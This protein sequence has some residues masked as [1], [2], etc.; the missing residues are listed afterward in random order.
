LPDTNVDEVIK[1]SDFVINCAD[2]PYIGYTS[3]KLSKK[4]YEMNK[5]H[6]IAGGFDI[7]VMS[8]GELIIPGVTPCVNCYMRY[9][10]KKLSNWTPENK[11]VIDY[12]NE[13]GGLASQSLFSASYCVTQ[14]FKYL[15]G[16][17]F[18]SEKLTRGEVDFETYKIQYLDVKRDPNCPV[19]GGL[20]SDEAKN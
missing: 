9:F 4:C 10:K 14:I 6:Y 19:C 3:I 15:C 7:H 2:E 1:N 5:P 13:Y 18:E 17:K 16:S 11:K 20:F 8:T 12:I